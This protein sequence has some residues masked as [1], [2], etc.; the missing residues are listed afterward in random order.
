LPTLRLTQV[1]ARPAH[2]V[3]RVIVDAGAFASWNPTIASSRQI[4]AGDPGPGAEFEWELRGFGAV[5]Q[6]LDEFEIDRRVRIVPEMRSVSGGH[7]FTL[8]NLGDETRVDHELEMTP[9]GAFVLMAPM[10]WFTGRR[11]LRATADALQ[12]RVEQ[13]TAGG[14]A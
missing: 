14:S 10:M 12:R 3:F 11:N 7:R 5:R 6:H 4:S 13:P 9:K 8:T 2:E 1:I